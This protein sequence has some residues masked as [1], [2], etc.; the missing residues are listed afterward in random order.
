[1][2]IQELLPDSVVVKK[3]LPGDHLVSVNGYEV[4]HSNVDVVLAKVALTAD[5][6]VLQVVR[7]S[8]SGQAA[9]AA[10]SMDSVNQ[11]LIKLLSRKGSQCSPKPV[12][13][14]PHMLMYLTLNTAEDDEENKVGISC[15]CVYNP[16]LC[17]TFCTCI[18]HK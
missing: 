6:L 15:M 9:M 5:E 11:E 8:G 16:S 10:T 7:G 1:M 2:I 17:R 3:I 14:L 13:R 12:H 18:L 4:H